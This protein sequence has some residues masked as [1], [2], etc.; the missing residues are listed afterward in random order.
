MAACLFVCTY[1]IRINNQSP[2][3]SY[4]EDRVFLPTLAPAYYSRNKWMIACR[5]AGSGRW[6]WVAAIVLRAETVQK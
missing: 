1:V 6:G 4:L 3:P 2:D 5:V